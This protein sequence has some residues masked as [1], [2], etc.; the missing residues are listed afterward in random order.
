M[1]KILIIIL[2]LSSFVFYAGCNEYACSCK[3]LTE[4]MSGRNVVIA[5]H[6]DRDIDINGRLDEPQWE[7]AEKY[8]LALYEKY[9][10]ITYHKNENNG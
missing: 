1:V 8:V 7:K 3:R 6:T 2:S 4:N 5:K 9:Y 10:I